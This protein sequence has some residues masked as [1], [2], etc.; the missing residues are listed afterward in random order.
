MAVEAERG[1]ALEG[2]VMVVDGYPGKPAG[3]NLRLRNASLA[4]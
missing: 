3:G 4:F 2:V 1:A